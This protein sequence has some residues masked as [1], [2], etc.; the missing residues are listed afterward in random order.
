MDDQRNCVRILDNRLYS[1]AFM[2]INYTTSDVHRE[3]DI[4]NPHIHSDVMVL[5]CEN[6]PSHHPYWYARVL[7]I[8][9]AYVHHC[10][11]DSWDSSIQPMEILW[12]C[13]YGT[14]PG[15]RHS[16][17]VARLPKVGLVLDSDPA[18]FGFLDPSLVIRGCHLIPAF[19]DG[20]TTN[21]LRAGPLLG[22]VPCEVDDWS[23]YYVNV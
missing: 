3:Q 6:K 19:C 16:S 21:L 17:T 20:R 9:C 15:Y 10:G 14:V 13:W 22:Q 18:A 1:V 12:V 7:R 23:T 5:L 4:I 8:F 2:Q 11:R